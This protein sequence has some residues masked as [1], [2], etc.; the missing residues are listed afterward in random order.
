[1]LAED[2][3]IHK[4]YTPYDSSARAQGRMK[5]AQ[6]VEAIL[7]TLKCGRETR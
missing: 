3:T 1:M 6:S 4:A 5:G 7:M 2:F